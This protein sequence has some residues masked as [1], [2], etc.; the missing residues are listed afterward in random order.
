[1]ERDPDP[2]RGTT[3]MTPPRLA[4]WWIAR[5][6]PVY[7]QDGL[8]DDLQEAFMSVTA[9]RGPRRARRWYWRQALASTPALFRM[10]RNGPRRPPA[11]SAL[12][13]IAWLRDLWL[14]LRTLTRTPGFTAA[15]MLTFALGIGVNIAVLSAVDRI[16]FRPLPFGDAGRLV[17]IHSL[18]RTGASPASYLPG[19]LAYRIKTEARSFEAVATDD[20]NVPPLPLNDGSGVWLTLHYASDNLLSVL[21]VSP[22]TGRDF[23]IDDARL[24]TRAVLLT[25]E[26]WQ[27]QFGRSPEVFRRTLGS[28]RAAAQIVG[29]LPRGFLSPA[30]AL[31]EHIDGL[32]VI[33]DAF[34]E[35]A[36]AGEIGPAV[37]ARLRPGVR[38]EEARAEVDAIAS[39]LLRETPAMQKTL[40]STPTVQPLRAGLFFLYRPYIWLIEA[41][42]S[43]VFLLACVN[44][45]MLCLA[46]GR[47]RERE[48]AVRSALGA[49]RPQ[50][51]R[52]VLAEVVVLCTTSAAIAIVAWY[53]LAATTIALIPAPMRGLAASPLE[54]RLLAISL[55]A[56]LAAAFVSGAFPAWRAASV[57]VLQGLRGDTRTGAAPVHGGRTLLAVEAAL[58]ILLVAGAATTVRNF[59]QLVLVSPGFDVTDLS[60]ATV[61]HGARPDQSPYTAARIDG[62]LDVVRAMPGVR[63]AA[64][65]SLLPIGRAQSGGHPFWSARG[66]S[67]D[68]PGVG[69][70]FFRTLGTP[71]LAGREFTDVDLDA[72][73]AIAIVNREGA[74]QLWPGVAL[75]N[76]V[77]RNVDDGGTTRMVVGVVENVKT[78]PGDA[79]LPSLFVPLTPAVDRVMSAV[80]VVLRMD[81]GRP[82]DRAWSTTL[83]TRLDERFG[84]G[85]A[86]AEDVASELAPYYERPRFQAVLFGAVAAI[87]LVLAGLGLYAVTAFDVARRRYEIGVRV[88]LGATTADIRRLIIRSAIQPLAIGAGFGLLAAWWAGRYLQAFVF[89]VNARDPLLYA[90]VVG[91]LLA[92]G[93]VAAWGPARRAA[94]TDPTTALRAM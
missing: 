65:T 60:H 16:M 64:V 74:A 68:H 6:A 34:K 66:I 40:Q 45:A 94:H 92:T 1:V 73:A 43:L 67:G 29:I 33:G 35:D 79:A 50:L 78:R 14:A 5:I 55:G 83:R 21:R 48:A 93:I 59:L 52:A 7:V 84:R 28:G 91:L 39:R 44:L 82:T 32:I 3:I 10:P 62:I 18:E 86:I 38:I 17:H 27:H 15:A 69:G 90:L 63:S 80:D 72:Q 8:L 88:S 22:I 56:A 51:I 12:S 85:Q 19:L 41:A 58:G 42:V 87:A 13:P 57:D 47:S 36:P 37:I 54:A 89:D 20:G 75:A 26:A 9:S 71:V 4:R 23:T 53:L 61:Q 49:S 70:G 31:T 46:R 81:H 24:W 77:G 2:E 30:S 76:V 11:T 25:D